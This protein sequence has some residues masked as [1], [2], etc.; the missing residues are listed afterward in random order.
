MN[1][2]KL[3]NKASLAQ[4]TRLWLDGVSCNDSL[5][6]ASVGLLC[7]PLS[8]QPCR[9][10]ECGPVSSLL[11]PGPLDPTMLCRAKGKSLVDLQPPNVFVRPV[12]VTRLRTQTKKAAEFSLRQKAFRRY[13]R[14]TAL[15]STFLAGE[16]VC[17]LT[18]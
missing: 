12:D 5:L 11:G 4:Y 3:Q 6:A 2:P 15:H 18:Y 1:L 7:H 16:L 13:V 14:Q 10:V 9:G 17:Q 8:Q